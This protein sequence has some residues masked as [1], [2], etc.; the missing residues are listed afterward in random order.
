[1]RSLLIAKRE[2]FSTFDVPTGYVILGLFPGLAAVLFFLTGPFFALDEASLRPFFSTM[3]WL[4]VMLA[5]AITMRLWAEERRS[6]TEE[7]L[8]TYPFRLRDLVLGK[9]LGAWAVLALALA[10]TLGVPITAEVL[11]DLDWGPVIGGYLSVLLLGGASLAIGLFLSSITDNQ[12]V[13]YLLGATV[14]MGFNLIG[15][16]S[17]AEAMP[18]GLARLFLMLDFGNHFHAITRGVLDFG[19]V[20]FYLGIIVFFLCANGVVLERRR[21]R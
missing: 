5:P 8:L 1:M 10:F 3:P 11:G 2:F 7:L 14:L 13:A 20:S 12:I 15:I 6:G 4:L 9:F 21:V 16:A 17:M 18:E 19:H